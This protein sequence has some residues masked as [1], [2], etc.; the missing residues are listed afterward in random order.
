MKRWLQLL[1]PYFAV[2]AFCYVWPNAW[3]AILVYHGQ[4]LFWRRLE[5]GAIWKPPRGPLF[6]L[7]LPTV[8]AGPALYF[9]LPVMTRTPL[10]GWL[11]TYHL[12]GL[13]LGCMI[14]YFGLV[15]PLLEEIH[16]RPLR[17]RTAW[18]HPV[19][20]GYHVLVL[21]TVLTVPWLA[22]ALVALTATSLAWKLMTRMTGTSAVAVLSHALADLGIVLAVWMRT[23]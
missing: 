19:F 14:P 4:I 20:A 1:A 16:W 3:L 17:E 11:E 9:L 23:R 5:L 15:H 10:A 8:L 22:L 18:S 2:V 6:L 13:S 21:A 12:S 7:A